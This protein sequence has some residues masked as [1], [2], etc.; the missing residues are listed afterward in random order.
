MSLRCLRFLSAGESHGPMLVGILDGLPAGIPVRAARIDADL[1]RRMQGYG[2]GKRMKIES[3]RARFVGGVRLGETLGG[4]VA[5]LIENKDWR[6]WKQVMAPEPAEGADEDGAAVAESGNRPS[7]VDARRI[8]RPRPGHADLAGGLKYDRAD[9]RDILERASAR[10]TASRVAAGALC[11]LLLEALDIEVASH[12]VR[13]GPAAVPGATEP[14]PW[15]RILEADDS[16]VRCVDAD[17]EAAMIEAIDAAHDDLETLGGSFEVVARG[18]PAGLG[19]H[20]QWDRKLEARL[21][22]A[23]LSIPAM[24]GVEIGPAAWAAGQPGSKVHDPIVRD[25]DSGELRRPTNRAGGTEGGITY[26]E[27]IRVIVHM[28]PLSTLRRPLPSVDVVTGETVDA[29]VQRSDVCA[30]P[31]AAVV[32]EAMLALVL[33]DACL[34]KFGG[35]S[36]GEVRRNLEGYREQ[37]RRFP[38]G[39]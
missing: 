24:K 4:P 15:E 7:P 2:R 27:E 3:D 32:G 14:P 37:M 6:N 26:G 34:E 1:Q 29:V 5:W 30:V 23:M 18:A 20:V 38:P 12:V 21:G 19:S 25:P 16:P 8:T 11:R 35:D 28:K 36:L 9:L 13:I 31:A 10:E 22:Q 39:S 17:A 33:A